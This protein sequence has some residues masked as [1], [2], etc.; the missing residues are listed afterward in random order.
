MLALIPFFADLSVGMLRPSGDVTIIM[1]GGIEEAQWRSNIWSWIPGNYFHLLQNVEVAQSY[2]I[3]CAHW[4]LRL[5]ILPCFLQLQ[6]P[7]CMHIK[8]C[9][10]PQIPALP[11][12]ASCSQPY[13]PSCM[14]SAIVRPVL[15]HS[16]EQAALGKP[17]PLKVPFEFQV[18]W[19]YIELWRSQ[20][21]KSLK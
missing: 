18:V 7:H 6:W 3:S 20:A 11:D 5:C 2:H 4:R 10:K 13:F 14:C 1:W 9:Q 17:Y 19:A 16:S 12:L 8:H 15:L 21:K